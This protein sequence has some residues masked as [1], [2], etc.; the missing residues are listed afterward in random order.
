[1]IK[2][3]LSE[4]QI[5]GVIIQTFSASSMLIGLWGLNGLYVA[6]LLVILAV[7]FLKPSINRRKNQPISGINKEESL[8]NHGG[9]QLLLLSL[10]FINAILV[11]AISEIPIGAIGAFSIY[12]IIAGALFYMVW[13][14]L[15]LRK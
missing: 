8:D 3:N 15:D 12:L 14:K 7:F 4:A 13:R 6:V 11:P 9:H 2:N 1:M 5:I 10:L